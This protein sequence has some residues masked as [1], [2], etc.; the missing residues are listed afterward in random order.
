MPMTDTP[1]LEVA[2][3]ANASLHDL[4]SLDVQEI[5]LISG[6]A[7]AMSITAS[8]KRAGMSGARAKK[9]LEDPAVKAH[10]EILNQDVFNEARRQVKYDMVD[11][12]MDIEMGK[13]MSANAME[14]FR[15]VEMHMKLHGLAV[16]KKEIEVNVTNIQK[17][18][19]LAELD[20]E[21]LLQLMGRDGNDLTPDGHIADG[22]DVDGAITE[23]E[24]STV[25]D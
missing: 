2:I 18:D 19:Q 8:A 10:L 14:W 17:I 7:M 20:D 11:A 21:Q 9:I 5:S 3:E 13:R 24:F 1:S 15:G 23:G 25:D 22:N 16:E 6:I 12:H 4:R